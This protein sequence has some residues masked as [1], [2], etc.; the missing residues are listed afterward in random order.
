MVLSL[1]SDPPNRNTE[2]GFAV[3]S[4]FTPVFGRVVGVPPSRYK[5]HRLQQRTKQVQHPALG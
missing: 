1:R 3:D 4:H 2:V 5:T